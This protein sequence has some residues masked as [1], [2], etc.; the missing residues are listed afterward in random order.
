MGCVIRL[1]HGLC[2]ALH[3]W[4]PKPPNLGVGLSVVVLFV[5]ELVVVVYRAGVVLVGC[6]GRLHDVFGVAWLRIGSS[7]VALFV[8]AM[9]VV[10]LLLLVCV[11]VS[12]GLFV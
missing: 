3:R 2:L 1:H 9:S 8:V 5:V 11:G 7:V 4:G 10:A 6:I 12:W